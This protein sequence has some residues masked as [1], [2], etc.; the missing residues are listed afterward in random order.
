MKTYYLLTKPG[1]I[2]GNLITMIGGFALASQNGFDFLL[3]LY[4]SI[5]LGLTIASACV[6]NNYMDRKADAKMSRTKS[7]PLA[8][9]LISGRKALF[10]ATALGLLG[11]ATLYFLTNPLAV[12]ISLLAFFIYVGLYSVWKYR[13]TS[14]TLIGSISGAL[15]PVIGY[16]AA[17]NQLDAGA[18]ILFAILVLWQMPHFYSI[19]LYRFEDYKNASIPVLPIKRGIYTTQV[20]MVLYIIAFIASTML[21]TFYGYTGVVYT[22]FAMALGLAWLALSVK[23][24][25]SEDKVQWARSMFRLSLVVVTALCVL[26]SVGC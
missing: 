18:F 12:A 17:K 14:A 6:F 8:A 11:I 2:M 23:G 21:L 22:C 19:A 7:R 5:G 1:I 3:F 25:K 13:T 16:C 9:G 4:V 26:I 10:F 20:Q 24:F 15:P